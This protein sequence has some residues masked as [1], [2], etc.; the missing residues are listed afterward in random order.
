MGLFEGGE[1]GESMASS[2]PKGYAS[3]NAKSQPAFIKILMN[4]PVHDSIFI[5]QI[6]YEFN[7][8]SAF[9]TSSL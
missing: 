6:I 2:E 5:F 4:M 7:S 9:S 3:H 1:R 8:H